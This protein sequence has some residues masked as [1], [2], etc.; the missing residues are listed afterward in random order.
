M[1]N[2]FLAVIISLGMLMST[3]IS[4]SAYTTIIGTEYSDLQLEIIAKNF[5]PHQY[6]FLPH[7]WIADRYGYAFG[8]SLFVNVYTVEGYTFDKN[9][10]PDLDIQKVEEPPTTGVENRYCVWFN[11]FDEAYYALPVFEENSNVL[12]VS[13]GYS[14]A[15]GI[16]ATPVTLSGVC[17]LMTSEQ[18]VEK[19][20]LICEYYG[21][22]E[23]ELFELCGINQTDSSGEITPDPT[24]SGDLDNN[25]KIQLNDVVILSQAISAENIDDVLCPQGKANADVFAD[26][27][28]DSADI[29]VFAS[30][31]VNS[32][33]SALPKLPE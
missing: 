13:M 7:E 6:K 1:K 11:S 23:E 3:G 17:R 10:F 5:F 24:I 15:A 14:K 25:G 21:I 33:L 12:S 28:I 8:F 26:G 4:T 19:A 16:Q 2:K 20:D 18:I 30:A 31:M 32:Q 9:D 22:T 27:K 29:S